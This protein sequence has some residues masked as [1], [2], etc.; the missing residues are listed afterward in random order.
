MHSCWN[1]LSLVWWDVTHL[2]FTL[3]PKWVSL[4]LYNPTKLCILHPAD[5]EKDLFQKKKIVLLIKMDFNLKLLVWIFFLNL[6]WLLCCLLLQI[7]ALHVL[8]HK[9][10]LDP[11]I[12]PLAKWAR[13]MLVLISTRNVYSS[14]WLLWYSLLCWLQIYSSICLKIEIQLSSTGKVTTIF[15]LKVYHQ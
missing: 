9:N 13:R 3:A 10:P 2:V 6:K 1:E 15:K 4:K 14:V 12:L 8:K 5:T 7:S 11:Q